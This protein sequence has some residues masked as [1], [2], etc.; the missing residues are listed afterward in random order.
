ML[1][2]LLLLLTPNYLLLSHIV[3]E[4]TAHEVNVAMLNL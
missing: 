3:Y 2:N 1:Q 4:V